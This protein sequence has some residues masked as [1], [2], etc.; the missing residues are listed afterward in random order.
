MNTIRAVFQDV[1]LLHE[2]GGWPKDIDM[3]E[4]DM[5]TRYRKKLEKDDQ[6]Q[7]SMLEMTSVFSPCFHNDVYASQITC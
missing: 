2:E 4:P 3:N 1:G 7:T 6:Y 5:V